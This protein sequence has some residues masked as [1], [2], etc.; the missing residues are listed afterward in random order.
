MRA[1]ALAVCAG[2]V[3][4]CGAQASTSRPPAVVVAF[5]RSDAPSACKPGA[6]AG[7]INALFAVSK[8]GRVG[9]LNSILARDEHFAW[10][11][12]TAG[13]GAERVWHEV[14]RSRKAVRGVFQRRHKAGE[15]SRLIAAEMRYDKRRGRMSVQPLYEYRASD[16]ADGSLRYGMGKASFSC[17][18]G[19]L[20][21]W[22]GA[23]DVGRSTPLRTSFCEKTAAHLVQRWEKNPVAVV[24][25]EAVR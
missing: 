1:V 14:G 2:L 10:Y 21:V 24:C 12:L 5:D 13:R 15:R 18:N 16:V 4:G 6:V 7:H 8:S 25:A 22:S 19:R 9:D 17:R 20:I 3:A 23:V 11:S